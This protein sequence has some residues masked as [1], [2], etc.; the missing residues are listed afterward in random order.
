MTSKMTKNRIAGSSGFTLIEVIAVLV[1]LGILAAVAVPKYLDLSD[2]AAERAVDAAIAEINGR[3]ALAWTKVM[4]STSGAPTDTAVWNEVE[5]ADGADDDDV[6]LGV[7]YQYTPTP[8]T[9]VPTSA[10]ISFQGGTGVGISRT[11]SD[12]TSPGFWVRS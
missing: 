10:D 9:G 12:T 5:A 7:D 1:L 8:A 2:A 11:V 3:E 6:D 4:L